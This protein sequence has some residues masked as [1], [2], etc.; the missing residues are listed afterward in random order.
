MSKALDKSMNI[1]TGSIL[2]FRAESTLSKI[3]CQLIPW[4][5]FLEIHIVL[6]KKKCI[7]RE[8][9]THN[10]LYATFSKN[11]KIDESRDTGH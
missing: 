4:N 11:L 8:I 5:V 9:G 3:P 7:R 1:D 2:S 10:W 6:R